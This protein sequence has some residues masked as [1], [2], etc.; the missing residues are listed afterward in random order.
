MQKLCTGI[1]YRNRENLKHELWFSIWRTK[2]FWILNS[3]EKSVQPER[4][5][6]FLMHY[7]PENPMI[8]FFLWKASSFTLLMV[9]DTV[10][11]VIVAKE[12]MILVQKIVGCK[13][14]TQWM[15]LKMQMKGINFFHMKGQVNVKFCKT[16][17]YFKPSI[18]ILLADW[19]FRSFLPTCASW[20][21]LLQGLTDIL[22]KLLIHLHHFKTDSM[23]IN[24]F[25]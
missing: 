20:K 19:N 10:L 2:F 25:F 18:G 15:T 13:K 14:R 4:N 7:L 11:K 12:M 23:E 1:S 9:W 21:C 22:D 6:Y 16:D 24:N 17:K 8:F 5:I 3:F